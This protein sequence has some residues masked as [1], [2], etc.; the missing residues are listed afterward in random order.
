MGSSA[1]KKKEKKKDFQVGLALCRAG[2]YIHSLT[3]CKEIKIEG[4]ESQTKAC[5]LYRY[6]LQV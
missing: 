4:W 3:L 6:Q 2:T 1:K 5:Q